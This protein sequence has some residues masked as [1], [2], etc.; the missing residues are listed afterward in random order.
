LFT[1]APASTRGATRRVLA[2]HEPSESHRVDAVTSTMAPIDR[3][4]D[5]GRLDPTQNAGVRGCNAP[6]KI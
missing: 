5:R 1:R 6:P 4:E 2:R 3:R